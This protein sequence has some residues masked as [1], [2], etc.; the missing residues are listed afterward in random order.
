MIRRHRAQLAVVV[1]L[2]VGCRGAKPSTTGDA[3]ATTAAP[4]PASSTKASTS[5]ATLPLVLVADVDLPGKPERFDYQD[6]DVG[7]GNLVITHMNDASVVVVKLADGS[8]VKEIPNTPRA[9]GVVVAPEVG[10]IF[11]TIKPDQLVILDTTTFAEVARVSAGNTPD[12][13]A[14]D[15]KEKMVGVSDQHDGAISLIADAGSGARRQLAL[16]K[17]TGNVVYDAA[18]G[19][20][21]IAVVQKSPP[22]QIVAIDPVAG[23]VTN[24][25]AVPGCAGAHGL[26]IHPDGKSALVACEDNSKMVR[27]DLDG[28]TSPTIVDCGKDPDVLAIDPGLGWLY[29]AAESGELT[30]F[31][32]G[33]P[34]LVEIDREKPGD[35]SHTVAVDP[36]T[37]HVFFPLLAGPKGTPILRIMKPSGT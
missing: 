7:K 15:P 28:K 8:L 22:D 31:D 25:I 11:V 5:T 6:L 19:V 34:G 21:W 30:V 32:I 14:W 23:K 2:L 29:V 35:A 1:A 36:A 37:H 10:R 24:T 27:V 13:V 18:R 33:K 9:R 26:R 3:P 12:G 20:F 17:D 16:G 4:S